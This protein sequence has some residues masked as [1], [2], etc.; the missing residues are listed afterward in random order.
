[1]NQRWLWNFPEGPCSPCCSPSDCQ[2]VTSTAAAI[3]WRANRV[4][5]YWTAVLCHTDHT[6]RASLFLLKSGF[7]CNAEISPCIRQ[8]IFLQLSLPTLGMTKSTRWDLNLP[9]GRLPCGCDAYLNSSHIQPLLSCLQAT[10]GR[11]R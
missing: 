9:F 1:M 11:P 2:S 10:G 7:C 6:V 8:F 4:E 5:H 3:G